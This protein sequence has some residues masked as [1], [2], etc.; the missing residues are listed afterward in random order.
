MG[1]S[2]EGGSED[3][4][5][6]PA[7]S[8]NSHQNP[9]VIVSNEVP[10]FEKLNEDL[11][12][13]AAPYSELPPPKR[14]KQRNLSC[15]NNCRQKVKAVINLFRKRFSRSKNVSWRLSKAKTKKSLLRTRVTL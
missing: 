11:C 14:T 6:P 3:P 10:P 1:G 4:K 13:P 2:P 8:H 12:D 9:P 7:I 5:Q 15:L